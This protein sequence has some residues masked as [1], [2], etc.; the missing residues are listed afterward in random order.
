[1]SLEIVNLLKSFLCSGLGNVQFQ[2]CLVLAGVG[3]GTPGAPGPLHYILIAS[4]LPALHRP[5][6]LDPCQEPPLCA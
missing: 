1:M 5:L 6:V 4:S 3:C 2:I